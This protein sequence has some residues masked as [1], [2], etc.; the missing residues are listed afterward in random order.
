MDSMSNLS[1]DTKTNFD[2]DISLY[3]MIGQDLARQLLL[4][5]INSFYADRST[6][7]EDK[8]GSIL[9][10][11]RFAT[12]L[13]KALSNSFG[14]SSFYYVEGLYFGYG[15]NYDEYFLQ[16]D[17]LSTYFVH[18]VERLNKQLLPEFHRIINEGVVREPQKIG[19]SKEQFHS[20]DKLIILSS[21]DDELMDEHLVDSMDVVCRLQKYSLD[22]VQRILK[23]RI[24]IMNVEAEKRII[25]TITDLVQGDVKLA[26]QILRWTCRCSKDDGGMILKV[27]HLNKALLLLR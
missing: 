19:L 22:E 11:G 3:T 26:I 25:D 5:W 17:A 13:A 2:N 16:G 23:Q 1:H 27:K 21:Y 6:G 24:Q 12:T 14:N 7:K 10:V 15:L 20:I 18:R 4:T 8:I 9:L